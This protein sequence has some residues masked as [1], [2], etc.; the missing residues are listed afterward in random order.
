MCGVSR[1]AFVGS[2]ADQTSIETV[3]GIIF[4]VPA[5]ASVYTMCRFRIRYSG[6][7]SGVRTISSDITDRTASIL[8]VP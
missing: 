6:I 3:P 7:L 8:V 2:Y 5:A 4:D 1:S